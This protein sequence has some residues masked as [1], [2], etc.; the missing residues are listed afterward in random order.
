MIFSSIPDEEHKSSG[1]DV[2]PAGL[3]FGVCTVV[4]CYRPVLPV[5]NGKVYSVFF[6]F[7]TCDMGCFYRSPQL[8]AVA[9]LTY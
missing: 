3:R 8:R 6:M 4:S 7:A 2:Y 5:C 9:L 1:V